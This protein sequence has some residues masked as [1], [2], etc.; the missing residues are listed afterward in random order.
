[1]SAR[2]EVT[3]ALLAWSGG[4]RE[5]LGRVLP[6]IY[7]ELRSIAAQ[8]LRKE[9][10]GHTLQATALVNEAFLRL[11]GRERVH[12]EAR[13]Q[14]FAVAAQAM[15]RVL[16]DHAR[17]R[18]AD[19]RGGRE[20]PVPLTEVAEAQ[21]ADSPQVDLIAVDDALQRLAALDERQARVV[22]LKF[23][24]GLEV[25]EIAAALDISPSTVQREWRMA[26]AWLRHQL[27]SGGEA[28]KAD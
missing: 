11:S 4:D 18:Q 24:A 1:M 27:A 2:G 17:R 22:E 15:R 21:L 6:Q 10:A 23:F 3:A 19:K 13:V 14:F 7:D 25:D 20:T 28:T 5:A 26:R 16:V 9:R 8:H 12:V